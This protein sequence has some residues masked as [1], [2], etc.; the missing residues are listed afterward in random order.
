MTTSENILFEQNCVLKFFAVIFGTFVSLCVQKFIL[1][2]IFG[3]TVLYFV[4]YPR[5]Y[6]LWLKTLLFLIPFFVSIL[7]LGIFFKTSFP[8][9]LFL[10]VRISFVI[11]LSV[12]L[13]HTGSLDGIL[14]QLSRYKKNKTVFAILHFIVST[15]I[16]IPLILKEISYV[17]ENPKNIFGIIVNS[18][19]S[20]FEKIKEV[21][22]IAYDKIMLSSE[23]KDFWI[24]PNLYLMLLIVFYNFSICL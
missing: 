13:A 12:Y 15:F 7:L 19:N 8:S 5:L 3:I 4:V 10:L 1:L 18:F 17:S 2:F 20:T 21:E 23:K 24:L 16:F 22:T 11:F 14:T 6:L 9:Q